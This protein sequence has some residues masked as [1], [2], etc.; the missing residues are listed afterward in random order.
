MARIGWYPNDR[1]SIAL[2]GYWGPEQA[3]NDDDRR[4]GAEVLVWRKFGKTSLWVQGDIGSEEGIDANWA[5]LGVWLAR[6]LSG[7][8]NVAL[9]ADYLN[10]GDGARTS[11]VL[12]FPT[13]TGQDLFSVTGTLNIRAWPN[14]LV[15][16]ELRFDSSSL[17][18]FDGEETQF[19]V[20]LSVAYLF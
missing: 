19:S 13:N 7:T 14:A 6:D 10:D 1:T 8:L 12:G 4:S 2:L 16:P 5:A 3:G 15:R 9:R 11:G 20:G 18:A 17:A